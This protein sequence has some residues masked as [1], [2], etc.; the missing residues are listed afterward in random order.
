[1]A[2]MEQQQQ[3]QQQQRVAVSDG[4]DFV[5]D[6]RR[7]ARKLGAVARACRGPRGRF[8]LLRAGESEGSGSVLLT[9]VSARLFAPLASRPSRP[10]VQLLVDAVTRHH[11]IHGDAGLLIMQM[12]TRY[13]PPTCHRRK[14]PCF[15][16]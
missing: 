1:M 11:A 9:T 8:Q 4:A 16:R 12:A 13:S 7:C 3:Q 5:L 15:Q 14:D 10:A 6:T 2:S